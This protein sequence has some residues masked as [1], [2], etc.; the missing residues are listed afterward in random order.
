MKAGTFE[1]GLALLVVCMGTASV[2]AFVG[3]G[4]GFSPS[5]SMQHTDTRPAKKL[6]A[7]S[8]DDD[9][10]SKLIGKRSQIKRKKNVE[11]PKEED[12]LENV[13]TSS[14]DY[15]EKMPEFQTKRVKR[16]PKKKE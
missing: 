5:A 9:E 10:L 13:D 7:S 4:F 16:T 8:M 12:F 1:Y 3:R 15:L 2:E 6:H 11:E 14:V